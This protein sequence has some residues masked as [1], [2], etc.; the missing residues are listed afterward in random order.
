FSMR[1]NRRFIAAI[2]LTLLTPLIDTNAW[3][4]ALQN[5]AGNRPAQAESKT[6]NDQNAEL[7]QQIRELTKQI[8]EL[9]DNQRKVIDALLLQIE[10]TRAD[11]LDE[12]L[13]AVENQAQNLA[14]QEA[15]LESRLNH[16]D[17]ELVIRNIVNR[18][19]GESIVRAELNSQ[20]EAV[21]TERA[22]V[23]TE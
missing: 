1:I 10:Q 12:K 11:K 20:L 8:K 21:R 19:E 15:Q 16:I 5:K 18:N 9:H 13:A 6:V 23:E 17:D 14:A 3:L 7:N 22:R 4:F 2:I